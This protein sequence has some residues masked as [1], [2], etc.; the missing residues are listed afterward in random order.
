MTCFAVDSYYGFNSVVKK[1]HPNPILSY[2]TPE[3][4]TV[5]YDHDY[6]LKYRWLGKTQRILL[7][8]TDVKTFPEGNMNFASITK[9]LSHSSSYECQKKKLKFIVK[10]KVCVDKKININSN[11]L[12]SY[13]KYTFEE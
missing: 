9:C 6:T 2:T 11:V 13:M 1:V 12:F 3:S 4:M 10:P 5:V 7:F 8:T